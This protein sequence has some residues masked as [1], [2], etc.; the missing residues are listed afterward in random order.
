MTTETTD[1]VSEIKIGFTVGILK[2]NE[3]VFNIH[4]ENPGVVE[5]LGLVQFAAKLVD[6]QLKEHL[7]LDE[8]AIFRKLEEVSVKIDQFKL[9]STPDAV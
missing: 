5:L 8:V 7:N 2:N 6:I 3:F 4:G 1:P 9:P